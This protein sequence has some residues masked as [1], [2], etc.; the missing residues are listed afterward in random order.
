MVPNPK[1]P[2]KWKDEK[3]IDELAK[4]ISDNPDFFEAR[5][6]LL[7]DRTG[8]LMIIGGERRWEAA[9]KLGLEEA[10]SYLFHGLTEEREDEIMHRDNVHSGVW[11][12]EKLAEITK[13]WGADK[14]ASWG[15]EKSE[16]RPMRDEYNV[17]P[18]ADSK[19]D[20][21][22]YEPHGDMPDIEQCVNLERMNE[23]LTKISTAKISKKERKI[24]EVCAYRFAEIDFSKMTEYYCHATKAM[25]KAMEDDALVIIDYDKAREMGLVEMRKDLLGLIDREIAEDVQE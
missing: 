25:Q 10:P 12:K 5:P 17:N 16:L 15:L 24:L 3:E 2:R 9:K 8:V 13:K 4:S 21:F 1:N 19:I 11:D 7:S 18:Y 14:V 6:I 22:I 20:N 23:V